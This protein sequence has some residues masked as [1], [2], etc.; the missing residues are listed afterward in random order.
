[1]SPESTQTNGGHHSD[2]Y[3]TPS[4]VFIYPKKKQTFS[5]GG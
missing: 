1:M 3:D 5:M 4:L 2:I